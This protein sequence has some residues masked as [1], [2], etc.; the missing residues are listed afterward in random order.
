MFKSVFV[1]NACPHTVN[2]NEYTELGWNMLFPV[3]LLVMI[4]RPVAIATE[5]VARIQEMQV[6]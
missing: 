3:L 2:L 5:G 1:H 4:C 6:Q